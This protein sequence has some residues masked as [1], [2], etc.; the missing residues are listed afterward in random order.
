MQ[1]ILT[2]TLNPALDLSTTVPVVEPGPKL[3]CAEP[4]AEP[5]GGGINV[6]RVIRKL[7]YESRAVVA[8]GGASGQ[9]LLEL[10]TAEGVACDV[11]GL[12]GETRQSLSVTDAAGAQYRFILPGPPWEADTL[13]GAITRLAALVEAGDMVVVSGSLPPGVPPELVEDLAGLCA[14]LG[15]ALVLDVSG[16][17]L[18]L[19][20][21]LEPPGVHVLRM[22]R[23]EAGEL[24]GV[25]EPDAEAALALARGIVA[26]GAARIVA[27]ALGAEGGLV[28]SA[29][30]AVRTVPPKVPVS[31]TTGAGDSY[32]AGLTLGLA[33]GWRLPRAAA[34]ATACAA[35]AVTTPGSALCSAEGVAEKLA[36][37]IVTEL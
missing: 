16:A 10:L 26:R 20:A 23:R 34:F 37:V 13:A 28:V 9:R 22:D 14:D 25:L 8:L 29:D 32:L 35:D 19:A 6:S 30:A 18:A 7:G 11:V 5:G 2:V 17:A 21:R 4:L 33:Q 1:R 3:R 27:L 36:G 12:P 31:S 15:A 24:V